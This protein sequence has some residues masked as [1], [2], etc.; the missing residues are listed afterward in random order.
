MK[1]KLKKH[2][3]RIY[4]T[5]ALS[6]KCRYLKSS[7]RNF[8]ENNFKDFLIYQKNISHVKTGSSHIKTDCYHN[9]TL[10]KAI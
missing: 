5:I 1:G 2:L 3:G 4:S 7:Y 8:W 10:E 6:D 9:L